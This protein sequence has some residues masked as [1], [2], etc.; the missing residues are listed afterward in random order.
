MD[1]ACALEPDNSKYLL[2]S[3]SLALKNKNLDAKSAELNNI[4]KKLERTRVFLTESKYP[5]I[6]HYFQSFISHWAMLM[7]YN[8]AGMQLRKRIIKLKGYKQ[9]QRKK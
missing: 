1:Q 7:N 6:H 2:A 4:V 8:S 9:I 3:S 5:T